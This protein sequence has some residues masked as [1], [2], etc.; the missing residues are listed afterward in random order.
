RVEQE[1]DALL[2]MYNMVRLLIRQAANEHGKDPC[3]IS[4][5]DACQHIIDVAPLMT[6]DCAAQRQHKFSYLLALMADCEVDR[7]RR[8]R[9][10][11]RVVKV[12]MS[13]FERKSKKHKSEKRNIEQELKIIWPSPDLTGRM[14]LPQI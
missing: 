2:I 12:K 5:L 11:P 10:N 13:K 3:L 1:L 14:E 9:I 4:F 8:P 6:A 7:P